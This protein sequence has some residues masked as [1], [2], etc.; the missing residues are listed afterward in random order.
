M[1]CAHQCDECQY[2]STNCLTCRGVERSPTPLCSCP[3]NKF[4]D[5]MSEECSDCIPNCDFCDDAMSC[6]SCT[7]PFYYNQTLG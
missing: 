2:I 7:A 1:E 4:D 3:I 5:F 6:F